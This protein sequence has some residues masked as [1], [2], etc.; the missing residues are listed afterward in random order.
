MPK[1]PPVVCYA[2]LAPSQLEAGRSLFAA[3]A[4]PDVQEPV[5][6]EQAL[7]VD[8]PVADDEGDGPGGIADAGG[9]IAPFLEAA[10]I[11]Q[12]GQFGERRIGGEKAE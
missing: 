5:G 11:Q 7:A 1:P 6:A 8:E 10:V 3:V 2:V 4:E 12:R 9:Q